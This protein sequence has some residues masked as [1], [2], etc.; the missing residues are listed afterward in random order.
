M[1]PYLDGDFKF[2][3]FKA[4]EIA[5]PIVFV[6]SAA[7]E[8][9]YFKAL[10]IDLSKTPLGTSDFLRGWIAWMPVLIPLIA[11]RLLSQ[12]FVFVSNGSSPEFK[13]PNMQ[14]SPAAIKLGKAVF[15]SLIALGASIAFSFIVIGEYIQLL[16]QSCIAAFATAIWIKLPT[17]GISKQHEE[18]TKF[19]LIPI[20]FVAYFSMN[21]FAEGSVVLDDELDISNL[22]LRQH[23]KTEGLSY[24]VIRVFDQWTLARIRPKNYIW[25]NHQSNHT[26]EFE[27]SRKRYQ[28]LWCVFDQSHCYIDVRERDSF[29]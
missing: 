20:V 15:W 10:G 2:K 13:S 29:R 24:D 6:I 3:L 8:Y 27:A 17:M 26:I 21:G 5:L 1:Q 14:R 23:I 18:S 9:F 7:Y 11:G 22:H 28:G 25:I 19:F 12:A 4:T 16:L